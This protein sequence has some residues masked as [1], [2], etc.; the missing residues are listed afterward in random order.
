MQDF[1]NRAVKRR[2]DFRPFAPAVTS[3]A[4]GTFFEGAMPSPY[5]TFVAGVRQEWRAVLPAVTHVDGSARLQTVD[6]EQNPAFHQLLTEFGRIT[7]IPVLL[8]TSFNGRSMPI[9]ETP[10]E[11]VAMFA[12]SPLHA[13]AAGNLLVVKSPDTQAPAVPE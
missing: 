1:I 12:S 10:Q 11:A 5:M 3:A 9:V 8:N 2:E 4:A 6:P 7:G 13:L